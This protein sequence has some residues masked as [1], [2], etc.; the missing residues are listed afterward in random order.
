MG[1]MGGGRCKGRGVRERSGR[2]RWMGEEGKRER[3][4]CGR[5][6]EGGEER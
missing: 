5:E 3:G 6:K 1:K 2:G 4:G